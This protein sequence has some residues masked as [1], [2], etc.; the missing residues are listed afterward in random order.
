MAS[1]SHL[2]ADAHL[3]ARIWHDWADTVGRRSSP[4]GFDAEHRNRFGGTGRTPW[5]G[6]AP[7]QDLTQSLAVASTSHF[8]AD[9]H[10]AARMWLQLGGLRGPAQLPDRI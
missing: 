2:R 3:T 6:V 1:T 9:A 4:A 8:R 5:A 7:Q 10:L